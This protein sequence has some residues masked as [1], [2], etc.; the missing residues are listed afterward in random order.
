MNP[1]QM[2]D[3][4]LIYCRDQSGQFNREEVLTRSK[5]VPKYVR[6]LLS[7]SLEHYYRVPQYKQ[8]KPELIKH[9]TDTE[10]MLCDL[11]GANDQETSAL[12]RAWHKEH[13]K[14]N[15]LPNYKATY[16]LDRNYINQRWEFGY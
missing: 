14:R 15:R 6:K 16:C 2:T 10:L 8:M 4:D 12:V 9:L 5:F 1:S 7:L 3:L 13:E 11:N